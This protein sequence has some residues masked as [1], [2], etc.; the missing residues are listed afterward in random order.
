MGIFLLDKVEGRN[1][2]IHF[3]KDGLGERGSLS[4]GKGKKKKKNFAGVCGGDG[5]NLFRKVEIK[6]LY[7]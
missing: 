2:W 4:K 7:W 1:Q 5:L 3:S 6:V